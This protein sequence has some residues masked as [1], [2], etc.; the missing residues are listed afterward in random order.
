MMVG[1]QH[2]RYVIIP[3]WI[4]SRND[5]QRH[6]IGVGQLCELYR[7]PPGA[8]ILVLRDYQ[9]RLGYRPIPGDYVCEPRFDGQY[10]AFLA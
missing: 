8:P 10:P 5:A 3:G 4:V 6:W 9:S 2:T 1:M 7:V